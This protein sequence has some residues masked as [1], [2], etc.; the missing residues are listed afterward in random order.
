[1]T[2]RPVVARVSQA[3]RPLGSCFITSARTASEIWS[4][5]LSGWPS[6]TDSDVNRKLRRAWLKQ[7]LLVGYVICALLACVSRPV[8]H[9][10]YRS[11]FPSSRTSS[12]LYKTT[13]RGAKN[14]RIDFKKL[15]GALNG[16]NQA[17]NGY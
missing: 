9:Q 16:R 3:T 10:K 7:I 17:P 11:G 15:I 13:I 6:V 1:M 8:F 2:A 5:I 12:S 14:Q 4:A